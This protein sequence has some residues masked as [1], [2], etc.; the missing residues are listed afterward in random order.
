MSTFSSGGRDL[1]GWKVLR[2]LHGTMYGKAELEDLTGR[3][4]YETQ[5]PFVSP[6]AGASIDMKAGTSIWWSHNEDDL[7][8]HWEIRRI[9]RL[10]A[11]WRGLLASS[12]DDTGMADADC[13]IEITSDF[14]IGAVHRYQGGDTE[15]TLTVRHQIKPEGWLSTVEISFV[16]EGSSSDLLLARG[17]PKRLLED[18]ERLGWHLHGEIPESM[19]YDADTQEVMIRIPVRSL[20]W[21]DR[22]EPV[23]ETRGRS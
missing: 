4:V 3:I 14:I 2:D 20:Q 10:A 16:W 13:W 23:D 12:I 5:M 6:E 8:H 19:E 17:N 21:I 9:D 22:Q 7:D 18:V 1:S 15:S 11:G